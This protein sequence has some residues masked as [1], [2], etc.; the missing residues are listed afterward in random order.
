MAAVVR[1]RA[2]AIRVMVTAKEQGD[3]ESGEQ[4]GD[5]DVGLCPR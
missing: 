2:I 4:G 1:K 5:A 3:Q